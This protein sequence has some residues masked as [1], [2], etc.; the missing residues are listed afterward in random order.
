LT[1]LQIPDDGPVDDTA[2]TTSAAPP[3]QAPSMP[4][5]YLVP[6]LR[7]K[8]AIEGT[9]HVCKGVWALSDD[10][11]GKEGQTSDFEFR[12]VKPSPDN[13]RAFPMNG[14]YHG[15]FFLKQPPPLKSS[16]KIEDK[17]MT[18]TFT[19]TVN[20][21]YA[22]Q[23]DGSNKFGKFTLTG[24]LKPDGTAQMYRMYVSKPVLPKRSGSISGPATPGTTVRKRPLE[25]ESPRPV[26]VDAARTRKRPNFGDEMTPAAFSPRATSASELAAAATPR[27]PRLPPHLIKC[28]EILKEMLKQPQ[29]VWFLEPVDPVKLN[30]PDYPLI[31]KHPMDLGT[32]KA[33]LEGN[34]YS[35]PEGFAEHIRLVFK[36]ALAYNQMRDHPVH[37]A[38]REMSSKFEEKYRLL[39]SQ[40]GLNASSDAAVTPSSKKGAPKTPRLSS[41]GGGGGGGVG[42]Y[43]AKNRA[44]LSSVAGPR[45]T[46]VF[47]PPPLDSSAH[48]LAEMQRRMEEMHNEIMKL[49]TEVK[50]NELRIG[51]SSS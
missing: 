4:P 39:L 1:A 16:L 45:T 35:G 25:A 13:V 18:I 46:D 24:T 36:N 9:T 21:E 6:S 20:G 14:K 23:G 48:H 51:A 43:G 3:P 34:V 32:I 31:V 49:R 47:L 5:T 27:A 42:N 26:P 40:L 41:G 30:I 19:Q 38:A 33:N 2:S 12:L 29:S 10:Y 17:D 11:H 22:V 8:L 7:G 15:F 28:N 37:I 44:A 50:Q